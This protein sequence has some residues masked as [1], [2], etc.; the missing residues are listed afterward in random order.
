MKSCVLQTRIGVDLVPLAH[1]FRLLGKEITVLRLSS[2]DHGGIRTVVWL[3][4]LLEE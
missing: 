2:E 4:V 3:F 1:K